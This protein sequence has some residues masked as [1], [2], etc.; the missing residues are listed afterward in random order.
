MRTV[1]MKDVIA[2]KE[3]KYPPIEASQ[4]KSIVVT[5]ISR[6][7][8]FA[9]I[10]AIGVLSLVPGDDRPHTMLP[11]GIEH[12]LAYMGGAFF[13]CFAYRSRLSPIRVVVL[14]TAYGALLEL[15]QLWIPG[16][17]GQV[18]DAAVDFVGATIGVLIALAVVRVIPKSI[19]EN[20]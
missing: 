4:K 6:V 15:C 7:V 18:L 20:I 19:V 16:R 8:A 5:I 1:T 17:N 11:G 9:S 12:A 3:A 14:L 10:L 2:M 13:L